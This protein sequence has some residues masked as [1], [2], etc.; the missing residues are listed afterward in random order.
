MFVALLTNAMYVPDAQIDAEEDVAVTAVLEAKIKFADEVA[1]VT[2]PISSD[3]LN[4]AVAVGVAV[5]LVPTRTV[6]D[7]SPVPVLS[8]LLEPTFSHPISVLRTI[9]S[10]ESVF[11]TVELVAEVIATVIAAIF[12]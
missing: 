3:G 7:A 4:S 8:V 12:M 5:E 1:S 9:R 11:R 2:L 10:F 6:S